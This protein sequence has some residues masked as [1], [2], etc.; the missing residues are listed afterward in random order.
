MQWL[1]YAYKH[2]IPTN[3]L[4]EVANGEETFCFYC[5][6]DG[7]FVTKWL[8]WFI[9][10]PLQLQI[11]RRRSCC[12]FIWQ[13]FDIFYGN[14]VSQ[15]GYVLSLKCILGKYMYTLPQRESKVQSSNGQLWSLVCL[16]WLYHP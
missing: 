10:S 6:F 1:H 9:P 13:L 14:L 12:L 15:M 3:I 4:R 8:N 5:S 2:L 7:N 16:E 11:T